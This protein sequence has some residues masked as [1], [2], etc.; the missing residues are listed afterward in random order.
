MNKLV[1]KGHH[2]KHI[3]RARTTII[4]GIF[5]T[6]IL[7]LIGTGALI[8]TKAIT[9]DEAKDLLQFTLAPLLT[10]LTAVVAFYFATE[11]LSGS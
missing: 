3:H 4:L 5:A 6:I 10:V 11:N 8:A 7:V 2:L 1:S 9:A